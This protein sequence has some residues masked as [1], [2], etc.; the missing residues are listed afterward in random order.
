MKALKWIAW[1]LIV[2][3]VIIIILGIISLIMG[4]GLF[5]FVH[6]VNYF[7]V[8]NSLLLLA[9]ALFVAI[10]INNLEK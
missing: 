5:G 6:V 8:A 4:R 7:H 2:A 10:R 9:I 3:A 1:I